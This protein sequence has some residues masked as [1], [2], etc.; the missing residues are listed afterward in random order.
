MNRIRFRLIVLHI[1]AVLA[2][3]ARK[4]TLGDPLPVDTESV[5]GR[6]S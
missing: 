4:D 2:S 1:A 3:D 6:P 5:G